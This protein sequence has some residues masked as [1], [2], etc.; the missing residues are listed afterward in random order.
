MAVKTEEVTLNLLMYGSFKLS[1][2]VELTYASGFK[3]T[4][5]KM[6]T[7]VTPISWDTARSK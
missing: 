1:Q 5:C 3:L 7:T 6:G 2:S 4:I